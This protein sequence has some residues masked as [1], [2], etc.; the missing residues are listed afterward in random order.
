MTQVV[1]GL[2]VIVEICAQGQ[3]TAFWWRNRR[4]VVTE[5][6]CH[7]DDHC[8]IS[9]HWL[10]RTDWGERVTLIYDRSEDQ[11]FIDWASG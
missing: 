1:T 3:P 4:H 8:C 11:W 6:V 2:P 5:H 9:A 7:W 10:V